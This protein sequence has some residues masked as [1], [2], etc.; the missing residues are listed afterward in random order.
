MAMERRI[1]QLREKA[2]LSQ[3]ELG[4]AIGKSTATIRDMEY[5]RTASITDDVFESLCCV[6]GCQTGDILVHV[7][8][9]PLS[10][11][12]GESQTTG[13]KVADGPPESAP[14]VAKSG[15]RRSRRRVRG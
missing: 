1:K 14:V 15:A 5:G 4:L 2:G 13:Q 3:R 9:P 12:E 8:D 10:K 7:P 6:F 11:V